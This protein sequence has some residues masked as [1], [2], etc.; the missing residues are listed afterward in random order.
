MNLG[1]FAPVEQVRR[2][3]DEMGRL[4]IEQMIP[5]A[6]YDEATLPGAVE[7]RKEQEY[8]RDGVP[9][10]L[11]DIKRLEECAAEFGVTPPWKA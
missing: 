1:L 8:R 9:I 2:G 11:E 10:A 5:V 7:Y 3:V 6:G 4:A